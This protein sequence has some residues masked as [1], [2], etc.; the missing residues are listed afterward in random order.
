[1]GECGAK[2]G[3]VDGSP[4]GGV[5][6]GASGTDGGRLVGALTFGAKD[7]DRVDADFVA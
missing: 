3:T 7:F 1:M 6:A 2:G 4:S 5:V